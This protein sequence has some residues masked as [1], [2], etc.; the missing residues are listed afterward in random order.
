MSELAGPLQF[1]ELS[2]L[3]TAES[4]D[5]RD[6]INIRN[7]IGHR[8][9]D[10]FADISGKK[11]KL[12]GDYQYDYKALQRLN[13]YRRKIESGMGKHF[14]QEISFREMIFEEAELTMREELQRL[15]RRIT[16]QMEVR[17]AQVARKPSCTPSN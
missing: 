3:T 2:I 17:R 13:M 8:V 7:D 12:A 9:H 1:V 14:I 11:L 5:L 6:I 4:D 16:K 10:L 15:D